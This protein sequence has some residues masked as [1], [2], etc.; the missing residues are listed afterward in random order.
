MLGFDYFVFGLASMEDSASSPH[1]TETRPSAR[2]IRCQLHGSARLS[3]SA[4][5]FLNQK[6][7]GHGSAQE[8][9]LKAKRPGVA[10]ACFSTK[11]SVPYRQVLSSEIFIFHKDFF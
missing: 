9:P 7:R 3:S 4:V 1:M 8:S 5:V 2:A 6:W 11:A 10:E